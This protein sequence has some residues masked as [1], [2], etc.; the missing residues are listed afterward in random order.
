MEPQKPEVNPIISIGSI[1]PYEGLK[2]VGN[3][4]RGYFD[5]R[6]VDKTQP[7]RFPDERIDV[8][9]YD[10]DKTMWHLVPLN[11]IEGIAK[12]MTFG[13]KK[14]SEDGWKSQDLEIKRIYSAMMRHYTAML[15][16]EYLD[17]ES[18]LPHAYHFATNATF[19]AYK[20]TQE[21]VNL[22]GAK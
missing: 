3:R 2:S 14:Y 16:G 21:V 19:I 15:N 4:P 7:G 17:P 13:A 5:P 20:N 18:G 11:V 12:V 1:D 9:K 22:T 10:T 8:L 6:P